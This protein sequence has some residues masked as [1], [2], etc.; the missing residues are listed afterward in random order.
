MSSVTPEGRIEHLDLLRGVATLGIL[1]MNVVSFALVDPAYYRLDAG[2]FTSLLDKVVGVLGEVFVDQKMMGLFSLLFGASIVLFVERVGT[3]R[4]HPVWLSLWRNLLLLGIGLVHMWFWYGDVLTI[5][6]LCAPAVLALRKVPPRLL[7]AMGALLFASTAV[8]ALVVQSG[9]NSNG[10]EDLGWLWV[11]GDLDASAAVEAWVWF[12]AFARALAMML[13][14][15]ALYRSGFLGGRLPIASYRRTAVIGLALGLP[16]AVAGVTWQLATGFS[17][18]IALSSGVLNTI[19]TIPMTIGYAGLLMLWSLA[20]PDG[21][22]GALQG[23][24]RA[25]GRMALTNYLVQTTLGLVVLG[26]LLVEV[27]LSRSVLIVFVLAVWAVELAW[28][29]PWLAHFSNGP[30]E[31]VW[32]VATYLRWQPL[33]SDR[34]GPGAGG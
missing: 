3:R 16:F 5:Y 24:L 7:I 17:F 15:V 27:D 21:I 11:S 2:G 19:A 12:E 33:R 10:A 30:V 22:G 4:K 34:P 25:V 29:Q 9:V 26:W 18:R 32:R 8:L 28:S 13:V 31:W 6:A 20:R 14:G 1:P 23:R